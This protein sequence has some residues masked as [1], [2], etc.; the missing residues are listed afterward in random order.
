MIISKL[1]TINLLI[2]SELAEA[3]AWQKDINI[4]VVSSEIADDN[5]NPPPTNQD[6]N[7]SIESNT[8][9]YQVNSNDS[10]ITRAWLVVVLVILT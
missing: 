9:Y 4:K 7:V 3:K 1:E 2:S 6:V 8:P 5:D 10:V